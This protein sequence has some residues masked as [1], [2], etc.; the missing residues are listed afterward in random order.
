MKGIFPKGL[1]LDTA[2]DFNRFCLYVQVISKATRYGQSFKKG[3]RDSME[4]MA[5][6]A[7]MQAEYDAEIGLT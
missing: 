3:H 2:E 1:V 7:I 6:Y 4:D 5:V